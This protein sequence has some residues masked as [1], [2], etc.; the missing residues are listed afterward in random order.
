ME[1]I[2]GGSGWA[3]G[4]TKPRPMKYAPPTMPPA[5]IAGRARVVAQPV[6]EAKSTFSGSHS[7]TP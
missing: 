4:S 6:V 2:L 1:Y 7:T 3:D 5:M